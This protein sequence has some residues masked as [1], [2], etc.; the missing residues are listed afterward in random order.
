MDHH[1]KWIRRLAGPLSIIFLFLLTGCWDLVEIEERGIVTAIAIDFP[2]TREAEEREAEEAPEH[3]GDHRWRLVFTQQI[4]VPEA[5]GVT[6]DGGGKKKPYVN[7]ASEGDTLFEIVRNYSTRI[8][9]PP[10]YEHLYVILISEDV[11]RS[12]RLDQL[13]HFFLREHEIRRTVKMMIVKGE[14]RK[15]LEVPTKTEDFPALELLRLTDNLN[16]TTRTAP[17]LKLGD[18]SKRLVNDDSFT[19]PRVVT[20]ENGV[21]MA[22]L[23]VFKGKEKKMIGWLGEEETEGYNWITGQG[24]GGIIEA[25]DDKTRLPI[26]Y[27]IKSIQSR[28]R[29]QVNKG[30]ISFT[31]DLESEGYLSEDWPIP[32]NAFD[33]NYIRR[34]ERETEEEV[35]LLAEKV[36]QKT[37]KTFKADVFRFGQKL[38]I[39]YPEVWR[40]VKKDW[41][42]RFS[43][44][45][46][47]VNVK[48]HIRKYGTRGTKDASP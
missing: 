28:I 10:Y 32:G 22:G 14:A 12:I 4:V 23:A 2:K 18:I 5:I 48:I 17:P 13:I 29:P 24:Q 30:N 40:R 34:A 43:R 31:V 3:K 41:D 47:R 44:V 8:S 20:D 38:S 37:Q 25:V 45:P 9:R 42:E 6:T 11:A 46:V 16:K 27:E 15:A 33:E 26:V 7:M 35:K 36:L 1:K 39:A 21:K 19:V